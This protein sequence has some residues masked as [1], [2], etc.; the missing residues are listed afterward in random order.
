MH[1]RS[2]CSSRF[3]S[4]LTSNRLLAIFLVFPLFFVLSRL[5]PVLRIVPTPLVG[6]L[7]NNV[8]FFLIITLR[9][10]HNLRRLSK[11]EQYGSGDRP[12]LPWRLVPLPAEEIR[13]SF[14]QVGYRF[15]RGGAY[16]EKRTPA[17]LGTTLLYGGL[18]LAILIGTVDYV[19]QYSTVLL[20]GEGNPIQVGTSPGLLLGK[21][22]LFSTSE[23]P[24]LQVKRQILPDSRWPQGASEIVLLSKDNVELARKTVAWG[25][26]P[27]IYDGIEYH[28]GRFLYDTVLKIGSTTGYLEFNDDI[29]MLP[30]WSGKLTPPFTHWTTFKGIRDDWTAMYDP[31]TKALRLEISEN[32]VPA[33]S[34][35]IVFQK[36]LKKIIG[37]FSVAIDYFGSWSEIHVVRHRHMP[38]IICGALVA[39]IGAL[40][41]LFFGP[42][43]LWLEDSVD[44]CRVQAIGRTTRR[45][46]EQK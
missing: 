45:L 40:L 41:R 15:E 25:G 16:G 20:V 13:R 19:R 12:S 18:L 24:Q 39:L 22:F 44:G 4:A 11:E 21:G 6:L 8:C 3:Y 10:I 17:F 36:D 26:E 2:C 23:L 32:G 31:K 34:G 35:Q 29:K 42:Q 28:M 14:E 9:F 5:Y 46:L 38:L 30:D 1:N 43:R 7:A 27:L 33:G 37:G